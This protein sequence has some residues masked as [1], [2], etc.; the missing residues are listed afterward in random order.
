MV[1]PEL[2]VFAPSIASSSASGR[3]SPVRWWRVKP[4]STSRSH[5]QCSSICEGASTKSRSVLV[6]LKRACAARVSVWWS[7]WPNSWKS[8]STSEWRSREGAS[9]EG[10]V[11]F[12][13]MAL[14]G[15]WYEPS[16]SRRPLRRVKAA[17]WPKVSGR[18]N[19]SM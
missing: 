19:R 10:F 8:V 1:T 4:A 18:G 14:T 5:T 13:T 3:G 6:P 11:K 15:V 16:G 12:A 2:S 17:A 7:T 9:A